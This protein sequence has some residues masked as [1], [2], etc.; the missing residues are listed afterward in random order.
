MSTSTIIRTKVAVATA[1]LSIASLVG[2]G[3]IVNTPPAQASSSS[4]AFNVQ[5]RHGDPIVRWL[6][7]KP[8]KYSIK[9]TGSY[10]GFT[11]DVKWALSKAHSATGLRFKRVKYNKKH[12]HANNVQIVFKVIKYKNNELGLTSGAYG[13][14]ILGGKYITLNSNVMMTHIKNSN[15]RK[16][17][18][19]H[20]LGHAFGLG[21]SSSRKNVM[22]PRNTKLT[23][24]SKGDKAGLRRLVHK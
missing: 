19:L 9:T 6:K 23:H 13:K 8:V 12:P 5:T 21:H 11:K 22:Y 14:Q 3:S 24:Y 2:V 18:F 17:A 20:E 15:R 10:K 16:N 1:V 7:S 4:Y